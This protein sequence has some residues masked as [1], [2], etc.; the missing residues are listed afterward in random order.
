LPAAIEIPESIFPEFINQMV[1]LR[2][3]SSMILL[4]S[5]SKVGMQTT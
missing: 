4:T 1:R 3:L 5:R 2:G